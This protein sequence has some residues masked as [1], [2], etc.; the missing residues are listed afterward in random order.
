MCFIRR[1]LFYKRV[2]KNID[3]IKQIRKTLIEKNDMYFW[4][5]T[6]LETVKRLLGRKWVLNNLHISKFFGGYM[7][8][9]SGRKGNETNTNCCID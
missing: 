5:A 8:M 3:N 6:K 1:Y 7:I 4:S 2:I 9:I